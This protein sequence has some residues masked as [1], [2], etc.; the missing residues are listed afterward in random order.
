[1]VIALPASALWKVSI[2]RFG[3]SRLPKTSSR[4]H[5]DV[6]DL[7][8]CWHDDRLEWYDPSTGRHIVTLEDERAARIQAESQIETAEGRIREL[9]EELRRLRGE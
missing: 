9:E 6:L 7:D 3:S 8:T 1:M 4:G 5:S 2:G